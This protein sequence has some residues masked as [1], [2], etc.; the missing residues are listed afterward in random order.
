MKLMER[1]PREQSSHQSHDGY[2]DDGSSPGGRERPS[3]MQGMDMAS[4]PP[5]KRP[6]QD[7]PGTG[8]HELPDG[9]RPPPRDDAGGYGPPGRGGRGGWGPGGGLGP[10]A[11]LRRGGP[12]PRGG[13][14]GGGRGR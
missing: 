8:D 2:R 11:G 3:S 5:R 6:W 7:G 12:P 14:R 9:G 1:T 10:G 4:L 13:P